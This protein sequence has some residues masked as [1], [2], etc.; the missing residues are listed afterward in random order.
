MIK[1]LVLQTFRDLKAGVIRQPNFVFE[2]T[3]DR[4][5]ELKANLGDGF[6]VEVRIVEEDEMIVMQKNGVVESVKIGDI[7]DATILNISDNED[8]TIE[9]PFENAE[10]GEFVDDIKE[11]EVVTTVMEEIVPND[12]KGL[13]VAVSNHEVVTTT[14]P[15]H[16]GGGYYGLSNGEKVKGKEAAIEAEKA[17]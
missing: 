12:E 1:I 9:D 16:I 11:D 17:L 13:G 4:F 2:G 7:G 5:E 15:H 14:Y 8:E 3:P 10:T 6:V